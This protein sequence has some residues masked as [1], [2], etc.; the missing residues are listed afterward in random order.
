MLQNLLLNAIK[1]SPEGGPIGVRLTLAGEEV[2]IVVAD[3]GLGIDP[4]A[5]PRLFGRFFRAE[6]ATSRHLPGLGLGLYI[7]RSL[8]E[9]H[10]GR[11]WAE[12]AGAGR[13]SAFTVVL[14]CRPSAARS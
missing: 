5:L 1:Y 14:P 10:G 7:T 4:S 12:S 6:Q 8:V 11:I 13:G 3:E 2:E 9:A